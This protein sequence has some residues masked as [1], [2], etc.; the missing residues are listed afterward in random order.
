MML[1]AAKTILVAAALFF[2]VLGLTALIRPSNAKRFLLGF[3]TSAPKHYIELVARLL[4]GG[5]MLIAAPHSTHSTGLSVF[6]W[7]LIGTT[8][9]MAVVPWHVHR[10][11]AETSVPQALRFLPVIGV[12]SV[13]LGGLLLWS[14]FNA[15]AA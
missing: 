4:T 13:I 11:F 5:A 2:L 14:V 9:V 6:G 3:A 12:A 10:R 7:L 1:V 15:S 8:A